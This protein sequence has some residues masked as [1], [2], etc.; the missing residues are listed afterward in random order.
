MRQNKIPEE[1][2]DAIDA[3][4]EEVVNCVNGVVESAKTNNRLS[5]LYLTLALRKELSSN[6]N[7]KKFEERGEEVQN[8][9]ILYIVVFWGGIRR[10][11]KPG[12]KYI[13][14]KFKGLVGSDGDKSVPLERISSLSKVLAFFKPKDFFIYDSRVGLNLAF[15]E[16]IVASEENYSFPIPSGRS[17]RAMNFKAKFSKSN[18]RKSEENFYFKYCD[19]IKKTARKLDVGMD[20]MQAVE[21]RLFIPTKDEEWILPNYQEPKKLDEDV[22]ESIIKLTFLER[23]RK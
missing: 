2:R 5:S 1:T 15:L 22:I 16:M 8:A 21:S 7:Y 20:E 10:L 19:L 17:R 18:L 14:N 4:I 9:W 12:A 6:E 13:R 23:G 11:S 3:A